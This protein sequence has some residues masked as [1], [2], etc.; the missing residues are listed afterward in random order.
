MD[1]EWHSD[2]KVWIESTDKV[3]AESVLEAFIGKLRSEASSKELSPYHKG[4]FVGPFRLRHPFVSWAEFVV[5]VIDLGQELGAGWSVSG[6]IRVAPVGSSQRL[7]VPGVTM[8]EWRLERPWETQPRFNV[9]ERVR[10]SDSA[11]EDISGALGSIKARSHKTGH[12][13]YAVYVQEEGRVW[14]VDEA[15]LTPLSDN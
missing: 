10:V 5:N 4:G 6:P 7:S 15:D 1:Q 2:W 8:V 12:W 13:R 9:T 11:H 3:K 14:M